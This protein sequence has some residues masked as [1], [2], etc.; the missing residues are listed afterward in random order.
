M[1]AAYQRDVLQLQVVH[2]HHLCCR[3]GGGRYGG[4]GGATGGGKGVPVRGIV[5]MVCL[6][7]SVGRGTG[8]GDG[9]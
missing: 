8:S 4:C 1:L 6:V 7:G 9:G 2:L 3:V 5:S